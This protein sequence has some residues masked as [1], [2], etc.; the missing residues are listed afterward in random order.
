M[1][2]LL[3]VRLC[4]WP[5][6]S[7]TLYLVAIAVLLIGWW[8]AAPAAAQAVGLDR[9]GGQQLARVHPTPGRLA[10]AG[11]AGR[12]ALA[13]G[14]GLGNKINCRK[15]VHG[16]LSSLVPLVRSNDDRYRA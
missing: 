16:G 5:L 14:L 10:G 11:L 12:L 3:L 2:S 7:V 6:L 8:A 9:N 15:L 1:R 4:T 13:G